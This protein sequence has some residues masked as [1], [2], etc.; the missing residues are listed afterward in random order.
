MYC[1]CYV[2]MYDSHMI[3]VQ[4]CQ[5]VTLQSGFSVGFCINEKVICYQL[6]LGHI[7]TECSSRQGKSE[8]VQTN[9]TIYSHALLRIH[10]IRG[11]R[12]VCYLLS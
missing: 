4:L 10:V 8:E 12:S 1:L 3:Y 2:I 7:S 11:Q 5:C 9:I 6:Q